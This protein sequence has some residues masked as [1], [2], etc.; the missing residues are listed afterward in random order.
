MLITQAKDARAWDRLPEEVK[1]LIAL[2]C[3][4]AKDLLRCE[5]ILWP[6]RHPQS[7][8]WMGN[9]KLWDDLLRGVLRGVSP[10]VA[11]IL[12]RHRG[13]GHR[14]ASAPNVYGDINC[15]KTHTMRGPQSEDRANAHMFSVGIDLALLSGFEV[16]QMQFAGL[17]FLQRF[18]PK[19]PLTLQLT[20]MARDFAMNEAAS[21]RPT[22]GDCQPDMDD[23]FAEYGVEAGYQLFTDP[24]D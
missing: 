19:S 23:I 1:V 3:E 17:A 13:D 2:Q 20:T 18:A 8:K 16:Y 5:Q 24:L 11:T 21:G 15:A 9:P 10:P 22:R 14:Q 4:T 12:Q 6:I 7:G